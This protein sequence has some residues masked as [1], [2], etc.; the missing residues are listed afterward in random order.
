MNK[1][2]TAMLK[3]SQA[4]LK[5][6]KFEDAARAI[7]DS[8]K[9]LIGAMAGYV[10][11]L[12]KDGAENEV[13]FLDP[14]ELPCTVD[15]SLSMPIRGL[16]EKA[17]RTGK[18]VY[19]NDFSKSEWQKYMPEGH[20]RLENVLF[21]PLLLEE[22]AV[23]LLGLANKSGGFTEDDAHLSSTFGELAA[24][25]LL[26]SRTMEILKE[27]TDRIQMYLDVAGVIFVV[28]DADQKV[29]RVNRKGCQ[30][31]GYEENEIVGKNWFDN[32]LPERIRDGVK[33]VFNKLMSGE[34]EPVEYFE[35]PVLDKSGRERVIAWH[36]TV[37]KD[38][39]GNITG[40]LSSG[41][42]VTERKQAEEIL[43]ESE[44]KLRIIADTAQ[45]AI[46]IV[47]NGGIISFWNKAAEKIFGYAAGE[48]TGKCMHSLIT[49]Q[50]FREECIKGFETF[51]TTGQGPV[52]G[53]TLELTAVKKDGTEFP[54]EL[55][56]SAVKLKG[57][58]SATGIVRDIT[59]RKQAE[60]KIRR[61][62]EFLQKI[63]ESLS[64]PFYVIDAND[65][66]VILTNSASGFTVTPERKTC[67]ALTHRQDR[68][69]SDTGCRCPLETVK[70]T[71]KPV[72][73][74]HIHFDKDGN[75]A[76]IEIHGY[77]V[78]DDTGQ[79]VQMIEYALDITERKKFEEERERLILELQ[80]ALAR[81]KTLSGLL[82]ICASCK[83]IRDDKGYWKQIEVY[84]RDHS[85]AKFSHGYCPECAKKAMEEF[86]EWKKNNPEPDKSIT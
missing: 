70:K 82:P 53:K 27:K 19:D 43:R 32:F 61:Q 65:Y 1:E 4:I 66:T 76:L 78:V 11:L 47:D 52:V 37:L 6:Q 15:P 9:E 79:V 12:S 62:R 72:A 10:A 44:E 16:R 39:T 49:P 25:A 75:P 46:I 55:S 41:E 18:A 30:I 84:I 24:V 51:R 8:C 60:D 5:Y 59:K 80:N 58:W 83:K 67:F 35:N 40:S 77:P 74:E 38:K 63:I 81:I 33:S 48:A 7:F 29:S 86:E 22:K 31:L 2:I 50:E 64:H 13:L 28:I 14:G 17:Y 73:V 36:N 85:E 54:V 69:C 21:A 26:N 3:A 57:R 45:D 42:D 68:P 71:K 23:G 56:I 20:A 34:I